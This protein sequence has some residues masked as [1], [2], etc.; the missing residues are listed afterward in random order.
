MNFEIN[1]YLFIQTKLLDEAD[2][3]Q[4]LLYTKLNLK[5]I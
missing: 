3:G 2:F 1:D 4:N 5:I